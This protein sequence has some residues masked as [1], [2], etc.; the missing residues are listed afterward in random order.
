MPKFDYLNTEL[1]QLEKQNLRRKLTTIDSPQGPTIT[2]NGNN[3][4]LFA[5]NNYLNLA[6]DPAIVHSLTNI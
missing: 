4:S 1:D 2:V 5:S 3:L 6:N